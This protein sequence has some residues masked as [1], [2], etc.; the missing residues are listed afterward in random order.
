MESNHS[1]NCKTANVTNLIGKTGKEMAIFVRPLRYTTH[2]FLSSSKGVLSTLNTLGTL[3]Q[4]CQKL[5]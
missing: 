3:C 1:P 5:Q 4:R 2:L